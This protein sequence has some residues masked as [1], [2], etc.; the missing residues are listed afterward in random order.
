MKLLLKKTYNSE[1]FLKVMLISILT[2]FLFISNISAQT[3]LFQ[4]YSVEQGLPSSEIYAQVQDDDGYMWFATS[5]GVSRF[6]GYEFVNYT[7]KDGL[8][9]N[10]V[11]DM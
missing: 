5:K 9:T 4:H 10:S 3:S 1:Q 8:P 7:I 2:F 11:I 6:D